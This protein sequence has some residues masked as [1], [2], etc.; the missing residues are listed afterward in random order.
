MSSPIPLLEEQRRAALHSLNLL[1]SRPSPYLDA[2]TRS[3]ANFYNVP[4]VA[5][6]LVDTDRQWFKSIY[7]LDVQETARDVAFCA[8]TIMS[9]E[10]HVVVDALEDQRFCENPLVTGEPHI[11]FYA[12]APLT[13][14]GGINLGALCLIDNRPRPDITNFI[15]LELFAKEVIRE[16]MANKPADA[17]LVEKRLPDPFVQFEKVVVGERIIF[18]LEGELNKLNAAG[19]SL[20]LLSQIDR[21]IIKV[22]RINLSQCVMS[23]NVATDTIMQIINILDEHGIICE[24]R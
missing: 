10:T 2:L 4:I 19:L 20:D 5:I 13:L 14:A 3:A 1:D 7:G 18:T 8:H 17:A 6:S 16:V 9:D 24:C 12:G 21:N 15:D 11:R 23:D 22:V